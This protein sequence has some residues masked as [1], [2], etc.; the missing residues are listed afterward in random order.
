MPDSMRYSDEFKKCNRVISEIEKFKHTFGRLPEEIEIVNIMREQ[1]IILDEGCPCY[2]KKNSEFYTVW[3][4]TTLGESK[5]YDSR[6]QE[7]R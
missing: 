7:W 1:G 6:T 4:G 5:I 3:F 2:N